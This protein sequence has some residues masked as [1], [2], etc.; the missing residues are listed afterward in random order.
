MTND[1]RASCQPHETG[2]QDQNKTLFPNQL[3]W[4]QCTQWALLLWTRSTFR[5]T[6][7]INAVW[8]QST[9]RSKR[10]CPSDIS[11]TSSLNPGGL[12]EA[13]LLFPAGRFP[14]FLITL[15]WQLFRSTVWNS[16]KVITPAKTHGWSLGYKKCGTE[17]P[18]SPGVP[19]S[20]T[21][22]QDC[23]HQ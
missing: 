17:R 1:S 14:L 10:A 19:Q 6:R 3:M 15:D 2:A 12:F 16:W 22:F 23:H 11:F 20:P 4:G 21:W 5:A 18:L 7:R 13:S 9:H 8:F